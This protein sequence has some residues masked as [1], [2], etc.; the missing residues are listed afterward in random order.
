M[1]SPHAQFHRRVEAGIAAQDQQHIDRAR[2][3]V[4]HQI[5]QRRQ[6]VHRIGFDGSV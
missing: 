3:Q 4:L 2:I 6:L 5:L 1:R